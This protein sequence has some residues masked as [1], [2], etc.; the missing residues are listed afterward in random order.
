MID[1]IASPGTAVDIRLSS[2]ESVQQL[3]ARMAHILGGELSRMRADLS[4][5]SITGGTVHSAHEAADTL[6]AQQITLS[7]H[8][9]LSL[10]TQ[11]SV[12][13]EFKRQS[14]ELEEFQKASREKQRES[15]KDDGEQPDADDLENAQSDRVKQ[16]SEEPRQHQQDASSGGFESGMDTDTLVRVL[17]ES[18]EEFSRLLCDMEYSGTPALIVLPADHWLES[19]APSGIH[20]NEETNAEN[21]IPDFLVLCLGFDGQLGVDKQVWAFVYKQALCVGQANGVWTPESGL[22]LHSHWCISAEDMQSRVGKLISYCKDAKG[23]TNTTHGLL[24]SA[25]GL[26]AQI[27]YWS[28]MLGEWVWH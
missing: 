3:G 27:D 9:L 6:R 24:V 5:A 20:S 19:F 8:H 2:L 21:S 7:G 15:T 4:F 13:A 18:L 26:S 14:A 22:P 10:T 28:L 17:N 11:S 16:G 23:A 1:P 25:D 12:H